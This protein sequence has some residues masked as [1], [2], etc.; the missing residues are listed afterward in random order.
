MQKDY[1]SSMFMAKLITIA[2]R[3]KLMDKWIKKN[4]VYTYNIILFNLKKEGILTHILTWM[5]LVDIMLSEMSLS[6]KG[7]L[8]SSSAHTLIQ[9]Y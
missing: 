6:Q 2:K 4:A 8:L 5:N 7:Q 3:W 9:Q 1:F